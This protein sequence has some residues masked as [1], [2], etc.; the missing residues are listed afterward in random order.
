MAIIEK[1]GLMKYKDKAGNI[2]LMYP[3]TKTDNVDGLEDWDSAVLLKSDSTHWAQSTLPADVGWS[4]VCYGNGKFVAVAGGTAGT[5]IAAYSTDG[6]NWT[7]STLPVSKT[8]YSVW[9]GNG[10][11][12]AVGNSDI[13]V[14]STDGVNW[15]QST[16]PADA[17]WTTI[18]Y[19]N[20][21]F[22]TVASS[23][24]IAAYSAVFVADP[25]G[26]DVTGNLKTALG[27]ATMPEVNAA[28]QSAIQNTWEASY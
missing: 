2:Y 25:A 24:N 3:I 5:N 13:I 15:T 6:I 9:Y 16:L 8:W 17:S 1:T 20:G 21:K 19:G 14:Y 10:E 26:T 4:S 27:A 22:V 28:I 12:V 11:F 23:S 7:K 18:C